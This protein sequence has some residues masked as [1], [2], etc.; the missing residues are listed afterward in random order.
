[1]EY[2]T[3]QHLARIIQDT[4]KEIWIWNGS[5]LKSKYQTDI[6][7]KFIHDS[8]LPPVIHIDDGIKEDWINMKEL[9]KI[10]IHKRINLTVSNYIP[11]AQPPSQT[12]FKLE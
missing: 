8:G 9:T 3:F 6:K 12:V 1:M 10:T 4:D 5:H 11:A 7:C 2:S